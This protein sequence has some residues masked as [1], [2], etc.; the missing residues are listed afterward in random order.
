MDG[1]TKK[2]TKK[3]L[4]YVL[5]I[6]LALIWIVPIFTLV[7]TA[8]KHKKDFMSGLSLFQL[9]AEIAWDNFTNA[10]TK[11][12]LF[13][14]MKNDLIIFLP[15]GTAWYFCRCYGFLCAD[16]TEYQAPC[17]YLRILPYW[18]DASDAD[19]TGA[20]QH[21]LQQT[22]SSEYIFRIILCLYRIWYFL[23]YPD[24]ARIYAGNSERY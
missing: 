4:L 17:R 5:L 18:Y 7:A 10:I 8:L 13:T 19:S 3:I 16:K 14:Y 20:D 1:K 15:E 24:Y 11:G 9:P 21:H 22:E 23:L 2:I 6:V 12:N